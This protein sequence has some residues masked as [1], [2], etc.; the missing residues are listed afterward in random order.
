MRVSKIRRIGFQFHYMEKWERPFDERKAISNAIH[1]RVCES[2]I[3]SFNGAP[4]YSHFFVC[5]RKASPQNYINDRSWHVQM[6]AFLLCSYKIYGKQKPTPAT[7]AILSLTHV[8]KTKK[9]RT[10]ARA[11]KWPNGNFVWDGIFF[12]F[13]YS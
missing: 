3:Y 4:F 10:N 5:Y 13:I 11:F 12:N 9:N 2:S 6:F 1:F 8:S 7:R